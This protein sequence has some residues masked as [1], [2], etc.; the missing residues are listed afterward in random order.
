MLKEKNYRL[1]MLLNNKGENVSN[2]KQPWTFL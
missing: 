1:Q 2:N